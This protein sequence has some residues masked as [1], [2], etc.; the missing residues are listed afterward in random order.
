MSILDKYMNKIIY[1]DCIKVMKCL[2][3]DSIDLLLTDIPFDF[4]NMNSN[5]LR[6]LDKEK[7]D[8]ITF[9]LDIFLSE[10]VRITKG[11]IYVF[12]GPTQISRIIEFFKANNLSVRQLIWEKTNPSPMNGDFIWLSSVEN[13][14]Y[15]KKPKATFNEHCKGGVIRTPRGS[16]KRHPTE[17]PLGLFEY[18]VSVSSNEND[19]IFDPCIGSGT[20]AEAALKMNRRFIGVDLHKPYVKLARERIDVYLR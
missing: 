14:A 12:C 9:D 18:I 7:A 1:G 3:K 17:K 10:I 16:S 19:L 2:P 15:A 8:T 4:V 5:G 20:T 11:S 6:K 13:I